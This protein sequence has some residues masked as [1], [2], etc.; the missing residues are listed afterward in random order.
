MACAACEAVHVSSRTG[1][2]MER[3]GAKAT[4]NVF[5]LVHACDTATRGALVTLVASL[6]LSL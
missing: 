2:A 3:F 4:H 6:I 1:V 5:L